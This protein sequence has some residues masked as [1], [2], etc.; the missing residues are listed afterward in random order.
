M[1]DERV[2]FRGDIMPPPFTADFDGDSIS[3]FDE[4]FKIFDGDLARVPGSLVVF[5]VFIG[6][7]KPCNFDGDCYRFFGDKYD[8]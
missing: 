1:L 7:L 5:E 4:V 8:I 2:D 3:L 6:D